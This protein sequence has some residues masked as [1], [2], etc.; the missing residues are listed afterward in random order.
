MGFKFLFKIWLNSTVF[1]DYFTLEIST[2]DLY[3]NHW[4]MAKEAFTSGSR[5]S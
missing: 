5:S 2:L 1:G 3:L 4:R